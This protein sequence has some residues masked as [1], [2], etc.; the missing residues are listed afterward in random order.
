V[1]STRDGIFAL[2]GAPVAHEDHPQRALFAALLMQ[3][4]M[5]RYS[6]KLREGG[7]LP[8]EV[9]VGVNTGEVV[10]RSIPIGT[11]D[12]LSTPDWTYRQSRFTDAGTRA[13]G[14]DC[15]ERKRPR[16]CARVTF[17]CGRWADA[18]Q[19]P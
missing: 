10:V 17:F 6:S 9:R 5:R 18:G 8:V 11:K 2:F 13:D 4:E 3:E 15:R 7:D 12:I 1:Q 14:L 16:G 19:R